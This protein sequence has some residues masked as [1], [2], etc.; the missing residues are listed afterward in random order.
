[1]KI[2]YHLYENTKSKNSKFPLWKLYNYSVDWPDRLL[3]SRGVSTQP[4][5][6]RYAT[7]KEIEFYNN[8]S[9]MQAFTYPGFNELFQSELKNGVT[10]EKLKKIKN[11][12]YN[13]YRHFVAVKEIQGSLFFSCNSWTIDGNDL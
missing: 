12:F 4:F 1:M 6:I 5:A 11:L 2:S 8:C 7:E 9:R 13:Q 10:I 3:K